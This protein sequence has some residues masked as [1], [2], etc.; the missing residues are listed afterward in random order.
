MHLK[1]LA[2]LSHAII[3][4]AAGISFILHP[5]GQL[6]A[7]TPAG[8]LILRQYGGLLLASSMVC[9]VIVA[10]PDISLATTRLMAVALGS[11]HVWPCHRALIRIR[12]EALSGAKERTVLGG[13]LVHF[14]VHVI[15]LGLFL[16][17]AIA[18]V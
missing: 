18:D 14:I 9:L 8:K 4:T 10:D 13:P 17:V 12:T 6:P 5:E 15:C 7:C 3:E 11:Y 1:R 2:F 16:S